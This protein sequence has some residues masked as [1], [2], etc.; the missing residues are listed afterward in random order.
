MAIS[1]IPALAGF[2][3]AGLLGLVP[4]A[5]AQATTPTAQNEAQ[6]ATTG[7]GTSHR[8]KTEAAA[9]GHC[10]DDV[11]VWSS[12]PDLTYVPSTSPAFGRG[13]GFY[14]CKMEADS[15]GFH[16]ANP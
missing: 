9:H 11:I 6:G 5:L 14:A 12:G 3:L 16:A 13:N 15:A 2:A 10:A 4:T 7:L 8:F 1:K